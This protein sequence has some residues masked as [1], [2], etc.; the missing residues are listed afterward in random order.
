MNIFGILV[1]K[2][3]LTYLNANDS[4]DQAVEFLVESG[5]TAVPVIDDNGLYIG[6][7]SE[8]DFLRV[9]MENG[10][11]NLKN[12]KVADIVH[13]DKDGA[14]LNTVSGKEIYEKILDRNFLSVVD[15]RKCF[16]GIITRKSVILE[17]SK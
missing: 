13:Q 11:D 12:L 5:Y 15:D 2:Q 3:M 14:V 17:L 7:V 6:T 4:L 9:V 10:R 8:G 1:P 16:I